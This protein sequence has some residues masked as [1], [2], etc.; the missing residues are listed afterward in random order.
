MKRESKRFFFEKKKQK[1]F[2]SGGPALGRRMLLAG[3][4]AVGLAPAAFAADDTYTADRFTVTTSGAGPD[5]I[6]LPGLGCSADVWN[7]AVAGLGGRY[8]VH[9]VQIAGF[10]G[11]PVRGNAAGDVC[12]GVADGLAAYIAA[13]KLNRPALVGHS[14]GGTIGLMLAERH[15]EALGRL[16]VVEML[17]N[18]ALVMLPPDAPPDAVHNLAAAVGGGMEHADAGS[19]RR[20]VDR[21]LSSM[22]LTASARPEITRQNVA[23]DHG[24]A[25]RSMREI[26]ESNLTPG[27]GKIG[28]PVTVLYA[29]NSHAP[30]S[31]AQ[32]DFL[33]RNAY[34]GL[35]GAKLV[36]IDDSAHFVMIDQAA[37][38]EAAL[39][40]FLA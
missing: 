8:R 7:A 36:R 4:A 29:W 21:S 26:I 12:A 27:L 34:A 11:A 38:F 24:V 17:P 9:L 19:Y 25:G 18:L 40:S 20:S 2:V 13:Q 6:F 31:A 32:A 22:I 30:Y 37:K 28:I 5:V 10:A 16:M 14:M 3:L 15:P 39:G 35:H 23:S 33:Y 1:T